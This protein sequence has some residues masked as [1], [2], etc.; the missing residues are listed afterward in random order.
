MEREIEE[1]V[2]QPCD[3]QRS[4]EQSELADGYRVMQKLIAGGEGRWSDG[5]MKL[6]IDILDE[7]KA[8]LTKHGVHPP[9]DK[10]Q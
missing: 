2:A 3:H 7:M 4:D 10:P 8:V 9:P 5:C 6:A 1:Q